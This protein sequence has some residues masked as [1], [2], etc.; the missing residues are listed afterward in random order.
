M[1]IKPK[2]RIVREKPELLAGPETLN[3]VWYMDFMHDQLRNGLSFR[4]SNVTDDFNRE[5]L[6]SRLISRCR[7]NV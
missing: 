4:L 1:R 6:P 2:K 5:G 3:R 7:R